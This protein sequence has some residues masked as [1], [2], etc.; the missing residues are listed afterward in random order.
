MYNRSAILGEIMRVRPTFF[1]V[2]KLFRCCFTYCLGLFDIIKCDYFKTWDTVEK[3]SE[4]DG[5]M[6]VKLSLMN[7]SS[8]GLVSLCVKCL[9]QCDL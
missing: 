2:V 1:S 5:A 6:S 3:V 8:L 4:H 7:E 9:C